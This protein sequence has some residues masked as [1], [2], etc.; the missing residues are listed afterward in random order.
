M[1]VTK[2]PCT[3]VRG[4]T[5]KGVIFLSDD[6]PAQPAERDRVIRAAFGS[7]DPRQIDGLGGADPLT[8]KVA[9]VSRSESASADV[10]YTF[11]QVGIADDSLD[12]AVTCGNLA[13]GVALYALQAG[14]VETTEPSTTVRIHNTNKE[15]LIRATV[16][17]PAHPN[18][19]QD[20][21]PMAEG[22]PSSGTPIDLAFVDAIGA[23]TGTLLPTGHPTDRIALEGRGE[24]EVSIIDAGNLYLFVPAEQL[25]ATGQETAAALQNQPQLIATALEL[26]TAG[27]ALVNRQRLVPREILIKKLALLGSPAAG[28]RR[29]HR[30]ADLSARIISANGIVHKAYAVTGAICTG[31]AAMVEGTVVRQTVG[32][33]I[34]GTVRIAHPSGSLSIEIECTERDGGRWPV[35]AVIRRTARR[36]MDGHVYL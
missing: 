21:P 15:M 30:T 1:P 16:P 13:A 32:S 17:H 18:D 33:T 3:I 2:I 9:I 31:A 36:I 7:P 20:Q 27:S 28:D 10:E 12:Y 23:T 22:M 4:G 34:G 25:A 19:K 11:G 5:S 6:L 29:E 26:L 14:L 35:A 8:S 24:F